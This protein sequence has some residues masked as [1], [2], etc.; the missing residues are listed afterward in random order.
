MTTYKLFDKNREFK[1][2]EICDTSQSQ[3]HFNNLRVYGKSRA[4]HKEKMRRVGRVKDLG[5][6]D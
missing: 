2:M 5:A 1:I 6:E 4:P 3:G